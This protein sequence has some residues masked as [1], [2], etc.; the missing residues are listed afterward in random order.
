MVREDKSLDSRTAAVQS[1]EERLVAANPTS[2]M[3][4]SGAGSL[5]ALSAGAARAEEHRI[6]DG[7]GHF[8]DSR[9]N[10]GHYYPVLG[11]SVRVL[12]EGYRPYFFHD[13]A[14]YFYGGVW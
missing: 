3:P 13:H 5:A 12:P 8:L 6:L 10:H 7:R 2:A 4:G 14:Y 9:Y 1:I 11:G